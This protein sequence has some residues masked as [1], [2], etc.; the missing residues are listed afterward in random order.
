[1]NVA[2]LIQLR[3]SLLDIK[4]EIWRRV[5]VP[6]T[7]S[8]VELHAVLQGAMGWQD[9]HLHAFEIGGKRFEIPEDGSCDSNED[10][11]DERNFSLR[12]VLIDLQSFTYI[13][14]FGDDWE[15]LVEIEEPNTILP[16][17]MHWPICTEGANS[18]PPEDSGGSYKYPG[19]LMALENKNHPDHERLIEWCGRFDK[20][21]FSVNQS[22]LLIHATC[23]LYRD[24]G[25]GFL[26]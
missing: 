2:G 21:E 8:L 1:M 11:F 6:N 15:H 22:T 20:K 12:D 5:I 14:D 3:I 9:S 17:R 26:D 23:A 7:L 10:Y 4:P 13:Y 18:C 24:R 19:F 25:L 16:R